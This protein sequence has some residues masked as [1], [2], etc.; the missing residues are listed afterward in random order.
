MLQLHRLPGTQAEHTHGQGRG[1]K[2]ILHTLNNT[3]IAT[4]R[5]MVAILENYQRTDGS[6]EVPEALRKYMNGM[7]KLKP[8]K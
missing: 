3:A 8:L 1:E 5:A 2:R 6:I 7:E 4:S